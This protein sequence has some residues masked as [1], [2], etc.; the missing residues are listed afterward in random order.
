MIC[1]D[2]SREVHPAQSS[3]HA[4]VSQTLYC[5]DVLQSASWQHPHGVLTQ[6]ELTLTS[7]D[8]PYCKVSVR[9]SLWSFV[10]SWRP[11]LLCFMMV[12]SLVQEAIAENPNA[13]YLTYWHRHWAMGSH[14]HL[15]SRR[16]KLQTASSRRSEGAEIDAEFYL[17]Q[18]Y[19][20]DHCLPRCNITPHN[21]VPNR[22]SSCR[23]Q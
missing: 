12:V 5:T 8:T 1:A 18:K 13:K 14:L 7:Y 22:H 17:S 11:E 6:W 19:V 23:C 20:P 2:N 10:N 15:W 9:E 4:S 16:C 21:T 3:Q